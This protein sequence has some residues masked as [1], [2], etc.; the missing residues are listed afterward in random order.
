MQWYVYAA[1][2]AGGL[3]V[4]A[5]LVRFA[6]HHRK[7]RIKSKIGRMLTQM[8]PDMEIAFLSHDMIG[9][10]HGH[11]NVIVKLIVMSP[12]HELILASKDKWVINRKPSEWKK[13]SVPDFLPGVGA[14]RHITRQDDIT[15]SI[16]LVY[17]RAKIMRYYLNE[18]NVN[19][20][21]SGDVVHGSLFLDWDDFLEHMKRK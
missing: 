13:S 7:N 2:T 6:S 21:T 11:H 18:S 20:F 12:D 15:E 8:H 4:L 14:F 3:I 9:I 10:V 17:P 1:M 16:V 5:M 19:I